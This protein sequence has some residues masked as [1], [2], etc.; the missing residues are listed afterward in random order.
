MLSK[1]SCP[2]ITALRFNFSGSSLLCSYNDEDIHLFDT[3]T[4][5]EI[6]SFSG[7]RNCQTVKGVNFY[8][9]R[10]ENVISGSDCGNLFIWET[11]TGRLVNYQVIEIMKFV[12]KI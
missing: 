5:K 6:R 2:T 7:H 8:G 4:Y 9:N 12:I 3:K 10:S 11:A 1:A